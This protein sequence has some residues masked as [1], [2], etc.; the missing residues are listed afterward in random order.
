MSTTSII[1]RDHAHMAMMKFS[2][3]SCLRTPLVERRQ[4]A[5]NGGVIAFQLAAVP[6]ELLEP[7]SV[8]PVEVALETS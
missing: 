8:K 7:S 3:L 2:N 6:L 4:A 5:L 1:M